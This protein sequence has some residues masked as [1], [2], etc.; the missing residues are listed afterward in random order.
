MSGAV[1]LSSLKQ[2][3]AGA[4]GGDY[5]VGEADFETKVLRRSMQVPVVVALYSQRS[6]GSV[7]LVRTL[8]RLVAADGGSW[9]LATVEAEANMRIAQALRVQGIP[10]VIAIAAGQ[11]LADF[12]GAQPEPQVRQWLDAVVDAVA[13]KLEGGAGQPQPAEDPRF[14]AAEDALERGDLAGAEAAYE[15]ILAAEPNN[16]EAK[17]ALR[18]LRFLARAQ[19]V[20]DSALATADQDPANVDAA[21]AAADLELL[22]QRPEAAFDRLIAVV[23][24]TAGD[25]RTK[26]RTHLLELFELFDQAEPFVVAARR[27]LAAALY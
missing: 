21:I 5:A 19:Q 3:P 10:T 14:T 13:G 16:E 18:Q 7:E 1:D 12:E 11:P 27:K 20:P 15:A 4:T 6:P 17:G 8:E 22:N 26:A 2:P 24:R 25:D 9:E 23:K